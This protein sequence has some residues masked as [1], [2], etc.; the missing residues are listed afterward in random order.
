M[1]TQI[2]DSKRHQNTH[3]SYTQTSEGTERV[4]YL[5]EVPKTNTQRSTGRVLYAVW[6][7][8]AL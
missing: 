2:I 5:P 1:Q 7:Q 4:R 6:W 3:N 8:R